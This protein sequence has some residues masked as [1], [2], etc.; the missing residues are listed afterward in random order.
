VKRRTGFTLV[1]TLVVVVVIGLI[2][3][4]A[5]PK[6]NAA[7]AQSNVLSAKA[8]VMALYSTARATA[9]SANQ[10]AVLRL[11]GN[12]VYVY[13]YPRRSGAPLGVG[14]D[15]I[16]R[17]TNLS[18]AYGVSVSGGYDSVRVSSTGLGLDSARII[19]TKS[20]RVDTLSISRY[21]QVIK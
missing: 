20:G 13:A 19:L 10:T 11:N 4:I 16:V 5:L 21:G 15:T 1:E 6:L 18:T 2:G 8:K 17:P 12:Q 7:F 14:V 3:L 9:V